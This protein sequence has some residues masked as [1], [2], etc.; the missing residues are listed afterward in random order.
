MRIRRKTAVVVQTHQ[1]T[2][3]HL[4]RPSVSAW[5]APCRA[6]VVM[7]TPDEAAALA[8]RSTRDIYRRVEARELHSI[9]TDDGAL[10]VCVISLGGATSG[11]EGAAEAHD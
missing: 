11:S 4:A 8:Q 3:F 1:L 10:R 9:E 2:T 7:L 5:C 6:N